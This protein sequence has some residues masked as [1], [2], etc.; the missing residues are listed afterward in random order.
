[1]YYDLKVIFVY[2]SFKAS[3]LGSREQLCIMI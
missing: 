2:F 3:V 1:M